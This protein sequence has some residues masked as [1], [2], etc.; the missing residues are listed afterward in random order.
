[1]SG[2]AQVLDQP[3]GL[4]PASGSVAVPPVGSSNKEAP[5]S[6]VGLSELKPTGQEVE[7]KIDQELREL[8]VEE[9]KDRPNLTSE[10]KKLGLSHAEPHVPVSTIPPSNVVLPMSETE[11]A[12]KLKAGQDD[13]SGKWLAGL[14]NKIIAWGL[15]A[16]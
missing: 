11:I 14:L 4:A 2:D 13:D 16:R 15:K 7:H 6:T 12:S 10:H 3:S 9:K 1:M 5:I 8:G